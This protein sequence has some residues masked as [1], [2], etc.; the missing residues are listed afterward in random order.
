MSSDY[1]RKNIVVCNGGDTASNAI[2][3]HLLL[4]VFTIFESVMV[5]YG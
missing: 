1:I 3:I 4:K 2:K 5:T